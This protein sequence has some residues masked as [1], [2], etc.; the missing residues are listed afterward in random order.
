MAHL[1]EPAHTEHSVSLVGNKRSSWPREC[2]ELN[3][4]R[5]TEEVWQVIVCESQCFRNIR[6]TLKSNVAKNNEC[7]L[8]ELPQYVECQ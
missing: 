3:E 6:N 2:A 7:C 8:S 4:L 1:L 5:L